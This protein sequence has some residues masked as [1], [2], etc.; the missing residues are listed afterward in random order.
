[1]TNLL[2]RRR[3]LGLIGAAGAAALALAACGGSGDG[4]GSDP[5][6]DAADGGVLE[7]ITVG[8]SQFVQ[9]PALDAA[10]SGFKQAFLDA[11]YVEGE[12]ITFDEQNA[13]GDVAN[14][15]TIATTFA[16]DDLDLVLAVATPSA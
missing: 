16:G 6:D 14:T 2:P 1:M 4:A 5:T 7:P 15:T 10:T 13:Q 12:T 3:A 9:H 11:G 8:I